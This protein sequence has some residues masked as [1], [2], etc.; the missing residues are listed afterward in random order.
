MKLS[1]KIR[2]EL[3]HW[4]NCGLSSVELERQFESIIERNIS[5]KRCSNCIAANECAIKMMISKYA[6]LKRLP[7][8]QSCSLHEVK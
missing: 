8:D 4:F 3:Q 1:A 7:Q 5:S 2:Q 6:M